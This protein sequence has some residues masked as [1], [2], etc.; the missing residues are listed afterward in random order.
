MNDE[1]YVREGRDDDEAGLIALLGGVFA[2]Y[3]GCVLDVDGEMPEL[4]AI[5]TTF[6]RA[7]GRFWVAEL[8]G[9]IAGSIGFTPTPS[10]AIELRKL[11]VDRS[12]RR[13]GLGGRLCDRVEAEAR[14]RGAK[15]VELWSDTR[16]LDAHR[17][18]ERR[19]YVRG[20]TTRELHD[21]SA[22]VEYFFHLG[23]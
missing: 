12:A 7:G 11:Y 4:R 16:F 8:G 15:R 5:A 1:V 17:Q 20:P 9:R 13:R 3:P 18:Y 6:A 23:L 2:E 19:G 10:G 22:T 14:A 21:K